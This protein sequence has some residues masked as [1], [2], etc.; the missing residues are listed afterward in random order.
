VTGT[1]GWSAGREL[2]G[3]AL[4]KRVLATSVVP[5]DVSIIATEIALIEATDA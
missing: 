4:E 5:K 1:A 3:A 2:A